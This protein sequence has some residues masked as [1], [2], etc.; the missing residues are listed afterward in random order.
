MTDCPYKVGDLVLMVRRSG[1]DEDC[2]LG[3]LIDVRQKMRVTRVSSYLRNMW[4]MYG[5]PVDGTHAGCEVYF[6]SDMLD[7]YSTYKKGQMV[8]RVVHSNGQCSEQGIAVGDYESMTLAEIAAHV[9]KSPPL[10]VTGTKTRIEGV[11]FTILTRGIAE[12]DN[13]AVH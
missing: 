5:T 13:G 1:G 11:T 12:E 3:C 2:G 4:R 9:L 7:P 10:L 8:V 6:Y